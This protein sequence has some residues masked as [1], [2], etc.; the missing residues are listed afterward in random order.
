MDWIH[1]CLSCSTIE[2][3]SLEVDGRR[4]RRKAAAVIH[5]EQIRQ[6]SPDDS[7][8]IANKMGHEITRNAQRTR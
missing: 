7:T 5:V 3:I 1:G 4:D 2:D 8:I 6:R